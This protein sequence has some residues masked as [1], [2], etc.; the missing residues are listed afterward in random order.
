MKEKIVIIGAGDFQ[1]PLILKAK[2]MGFE[3]HVFAWKENA[4]GERNAD[5]FY[6]VSIVEKERILGICKSINPAAVLTIAS[7][8]ANITASYISEK[9]GL[10]TNSMECIRITTNKYEMRS[11]FA[12]NGISVPGFLRVNEKNAVEE[13]E[14]SGLK[15]PLIVKPT[16]RSGSRGITKITDKSEISAAVRE[17]VKNSF[18]KQAVVE[19]YIEGNEYS[20]EC[21]SF[22]GN[23]RLLSFTKKYTTGSPHFIETAHMEPSG[24]DEETEKKASEYIFKALDALKITCGASHS[25]FKIDENGNIKI[26][27]IGSRMGGD[28]IGSDLVRISTGYD[29]LKMTVQTALGM[30]PE[31]VKVC[32]PQ[33]AAIKFLF[34]AKDYGEFIKLRDEHPE[35]IRFISNMDS[36]MSHD[37]VDSSTRYGYYIVS[38]PDREVLKKMLGL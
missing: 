24:L 23:H 4:A 34:N 28:C 27:E 18:E 3:T 33:A 14:M 25:E 8:L 29:F 5:Y 13:I 12:K 31:F 30:S 2:E 16:D 10:S 22:N 37:I 35:I 19:E 9:L 26:I 7:D 21:I 38:H 15:Y 36:E 1:N 17:A 11:V 6:P 32:V 20:C